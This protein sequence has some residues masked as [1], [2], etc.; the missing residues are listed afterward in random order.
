MPEGRKI[1]F[2]NISSNNIK[3]WDVMP[4]GRTA[5]AALDRDRDSYIR[6]YEY[7]CQTKYV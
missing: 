5:D 4:E 6:A 7:V 2:A 1:I 3:Q